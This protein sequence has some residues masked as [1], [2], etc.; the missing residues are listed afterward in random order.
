MRV[1]TQAR[2]EQQRRAEL[3]HEVER[4]KQRR[5]QRELEK[6]ASRQAAAATTGG[7]ASASARPPPDAAAERAR[8][9]SRL[10]SIEQEV[11][12]AYGVSQYDVLAAQAAF[13]GD[14]DVAARFLAYPALS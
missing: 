8:F 14:A 4:I 9:A 10:V 7:G 13:T 12:G 1:A 6:E 5:E 3:I 2:E 11:N